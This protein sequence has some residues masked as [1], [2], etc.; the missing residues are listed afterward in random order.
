MEPNLDRLGGQMQ[1]PLTDDQLSLL[2]KNNLI[3]LNEIA[4]RVGDLIIAE[5]VITKQ[6]RVAT[7]SNVLIE[8]NKRILKG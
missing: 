2:R 4:Y 6:T 8:S 5:N 7:Q 1:T 3:E